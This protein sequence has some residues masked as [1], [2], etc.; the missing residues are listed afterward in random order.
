MGRTMSR[1]RLGWDW[2]TERDLD[3]S[4]REWRVIA[5]DVHTVIKPDG[6]DIGYHLVRN[7]RRIRKLLRRIGWR[8]AK[9]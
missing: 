2:Q 4:W 5:L 6:H 8:Q 9:R 1:I 3:L 7:T